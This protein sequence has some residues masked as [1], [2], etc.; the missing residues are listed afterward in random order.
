MLSR[1]TEN[2]QAAAKGWLEPLDDVWAQVGSRF[3]Q[4]LKE[5]STG[6]DG[7]I[8]A[9]PWGHGPWAVFY[10]RSLFASHGYSIPTTWT[11]YLA[12]AARMKSATGSPRSP[13]ATRRDGRAWACSTSSTCVRTATSST[14]T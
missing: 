6:D 13:W 7:R 14:S 9:I 4:A 1:A 2:R 10:R 11:E 8:Y 12:L 3:S 5:A